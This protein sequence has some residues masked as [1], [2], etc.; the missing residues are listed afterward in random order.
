MKYFE[1]H[2]GST[3]VAILVGSLAF[4]TPRWVTWENF[5]YGLLANI[6]ER[7]FSC[8]KGT[9]PVKWRLPLGFLNVMPRTIPLT[10]LEFSK[11]DIIRYTGNGIP[12]E[13]KKDSFGWYQDEI[14][15]VDY[16]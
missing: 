3:R 9:C 4:K 8:L 15:A 5:L 7:K 14:V 13:Y 1:I 16:A 2:R 12:V 6:Q 11:L 10:E